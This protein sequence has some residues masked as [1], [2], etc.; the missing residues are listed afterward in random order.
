MASIIPIDPVP[1][2]S[3][4]ITLDNNRYVIALNYGANI[5]SATIRRNDET[6]VSGQRCCAE[7]LIFP[8]KYLEAKSGNF[9]FQTENDELPNYQLFGA[10]Q[11]LIYI[12]N[13]ELEELRNGT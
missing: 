6:V 2:Q 13:S 5:M 3:F 4:S 11:F 12:P 9:I 7:Q 10:T 8:Y 1:N